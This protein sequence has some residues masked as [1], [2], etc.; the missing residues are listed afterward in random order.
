MKLNNETVY[1][2]YH[3]RENFKNPWAKLEFNIFQMFIRSIDLWSCISNETC[4]LPTDMHAFPVQ[5][6]PI[7]QTF[8]PNIG[9][10]L[11]W[12]RQ[13]QDSLS[14]FGSIFQPRLVLRAIRNP[15]P[16]LSIKS[17]PVVVR[18]LRNVW[19]TQRDFTIVSGGLVDHLEA[20]WSHIW[21]ILGEEAR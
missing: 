12:T 1:P 8:K 16:Q 5:L 4:A 20:F 19:V 18:S 11:I 6:K 7:I 21:I 14:Q 15:Y 17:K 13:F 9:I 10:K 2:L 3:G